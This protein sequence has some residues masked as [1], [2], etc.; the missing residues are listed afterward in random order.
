MNLYDNNDHPISKVN[1]LTEDAT[2][3]GDENFTAGKGTF[4][5][6]LGIYSN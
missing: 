4:E 5:L 2:V 6:R 1:S 3:R